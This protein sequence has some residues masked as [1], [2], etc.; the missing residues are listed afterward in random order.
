[1]ILRK[2][3][4]KGL[5]INYRYQKR[6]SIYFVVGV[7]MLLLIIFLVRNFG[8]C[9]IYTLQIEDENYSLQD[10]LLILTN[11][12]NILK[13]SNINYNGDIQNV[14]DIELSLCVEIDDS[15]EKIYTRKANSS[16]GM[17]LNESISSMIVDIYDNNKT[18]DIFTRKV[19]REI[20]ENLKLEIVLTPLGGEKIYKK[21]PVTTT[22][23]Y[24]NNK[25]F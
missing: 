18:T 12:T 11:K 14:S 10:G 25:L 17:N 2:K 16:E 4:K 21:I 3:K 8:N 13:L 1:M 20:D 9:K 19:K 15:C 24:S 22:I 23:E 5:K 6:H 7:I